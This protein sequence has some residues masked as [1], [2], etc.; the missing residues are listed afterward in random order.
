MQSL[1]TYLLRFLNRRKEIPFI[2]FFT[3]L[4]T[5]IITRIIAYSIHADVVP[6]FLFFVKT[7]YIKGY[8]IHH[9][10][11]GIV[12]LIVA[13]F[14]SLIDTTRNNIR[15]IAVLYGIGLT[16]VMDEFGLL[17]TLQ[18]DVYWNRASY[19]GIILTGLI[20]LNMVFF[21]HFWKVMGARIKR[22]LTLRRY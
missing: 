21:G 8:H 7:I 3:F 17:V 19:D 22:L 16:L 18:Q 20:L 4:V 9:F 12:L 6:D 5:F 10:N 13:G 15:K 14:L 1:K 2:I 11:I